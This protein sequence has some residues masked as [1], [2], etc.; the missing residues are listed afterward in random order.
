MSR[1]RTVSAETLVRVVA[2][3]ARGKDRFVTAIAGPPG[4]GKSTLASRLAHDL[5]A[6]SA[7]TAMVI[8]MDGFHY[9]NAVLKRRNLLARKGAPETFDFGGFLALLNRLLEP[10][11]EVAIPIFDRKLDLARAGAKLVTASHRILIVEGNYLL[12]DEPP[13][14]MLAG[15]FD[16][17][18]RLQVDLGEL[19]RRIVQRWLDHGYEPGEARARATSNDLPNAHRVLAKA[20]EP[21]LVV[22]AG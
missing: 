18:C 7:G 13:W 16:L 15:R 6:Q 19:E 5:N 21:D 4:S 14:S 20:L 9:D 10:A 2:E 11:E 22:T 17:T 3:L 1:A 8:P 12:L